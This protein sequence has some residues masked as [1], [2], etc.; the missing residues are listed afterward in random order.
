MHASPLLDQVRTVV[1][2]TVEDQA[3]FD[4]LRLPAEGVAPV[5]A[6]LIAV[7]AYEGRIPAERSPADR[8]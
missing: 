5:V 3:R 2:V 7:R 1:R 6:H 4:R 8:A